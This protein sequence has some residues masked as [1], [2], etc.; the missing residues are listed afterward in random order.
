MSLPFL[1][2]KKVAA[3]IVS[4]AKP[5]GKIESEGPVDEHSPALMEA[6]ENI[7]HAIALKDATALSDALLAAHMACGGYVEPMDEEV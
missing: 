2:P 4:K 3:V 7:L 1:N 5:D 6:S